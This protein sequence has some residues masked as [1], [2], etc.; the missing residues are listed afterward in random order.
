VTTDGFN[1][2]PA[3]SPDGKRILYSKRR[4]GPNATIWW[5]PAD[6]GIGAEQ[7]AASP[8]KDIWEGELTPDGKNVVYR[9]SLTP[10]DIVY[11]SLAGDTTEKGIATTQFAEYAPRLSPDGRWVAYASEESGTSQVYV[12]SFPGPGALVPVSVD[13][14][15]KPVWSPDGHKVF[16]VNES[17]LIEA[18][19]VTSPTFS[20][21][22]QRTLFE[23]RYETGFRH[24]G[25]DVGLDGKSFLM[26]RP[27]ETK[28]DQIVVI[29]HWA[30]ELQ[31]RA[32][33]PSLW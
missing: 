32:T 23:G 33:G 17:Q 22:S 15:T 21:T 6:G 16:Y 24:A 3:W 20:V 7:L 27:V 18:S 25:Y 5:Q 11:R 8:G 19:V 12:R 13:G 4:S 2:R 10:S 1:V 30:T 26:L 28:G 14:G 31:A 29:R 9:T